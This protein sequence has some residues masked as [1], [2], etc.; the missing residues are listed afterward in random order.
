MDL[1]LLL[2]P[3]GKEKQK[4]KQKNDQREKKEVKDE[5]QL[6]KMPQTLAPGRRP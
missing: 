2:L 1:S 6:T 4:Q 5:T 3:R